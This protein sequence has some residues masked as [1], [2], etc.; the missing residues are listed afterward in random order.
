[1]LHQQDNET[2]WR[3]NS[4]DKKFI[5]IN[6]LL[7][8]N[9]AALPIHCYVSGATDVNF[10]FLVLQIHFT[11]TLEWCSLVKNK[12]PD[13]AVS[14]LVYSFTQSCIITLAGCTTKRL[15]LRIHEYHTTWVITGETK[16][17]ATAI[18]QLLVK[19]NQLLNVTEAFRQIYKT[20]S[21][22]SRLPKWQDPLN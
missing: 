13:C 14:F 6:P 19:W 17:F 20:S 10:Y 9:I 2:T 12:V 5:C 3:K 1:M 7:K 21:T 16:P 15:Y 22:H 11:F 18:C 4:E 8:G